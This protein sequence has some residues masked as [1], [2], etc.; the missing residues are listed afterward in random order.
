MKRK[1]SFSA[2]FISAGL[3]VTLLMISCT[4]DPIN[5]ATKTAGSLALSTTTL[6]YGGNY[7]PSHVLAIWV[8]I[9]S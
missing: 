9:S 8:E 5:S 6:T 7:G 1:F 3:A 2:L 4:E